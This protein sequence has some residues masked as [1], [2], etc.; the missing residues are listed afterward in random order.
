MI[1]CLFVLVLVFC[2]KFIHGM[3]AGDGCETI[4]VLD[5]PPDAWTWYVLVRVRDSPE[6]KSRRGTLTVT[7]PTLCECAMGVVGVPLDYVFFFREML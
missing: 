6:H 5:Q 1:C 7:R 2:G 3:R 4:I